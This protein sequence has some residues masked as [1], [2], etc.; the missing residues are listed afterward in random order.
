MPCGLVRG[1]G[2]VRVRARV[3][4]AVRPEVSLVVVDPLGS[5][6]ARRVAAHLVR[7]RG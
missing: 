1:R 7:G 5:R 2:R 4:H 3:L 6:E